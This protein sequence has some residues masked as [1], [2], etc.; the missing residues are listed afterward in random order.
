MHNMQDVQAKFLILLS[1]C[2]FVF[3]IHATE[4][5]KCRSEPVLQRNSTDCPLTHGFA[6][7][8]GESGV[9]FGS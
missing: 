6:G 2:L 5:K 8:G 7:Q 3:P 9:L 4:R 1:H